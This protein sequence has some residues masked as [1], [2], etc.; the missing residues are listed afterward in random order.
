MGIE[1]ALITAAVGAGTS[2]YSANKQS[3]AAK[4]AGQVAQQ[5]AD[6]Q[7]ALNREIY[8]QQ[9][10]DYEPF[11]QF[12]IQRTNALGEMFGFDPVGGNGSQAGPSQGQYAGYGR[13]AAG[14][15][16]VAA[17]DDVQNAFNT[18]SPQNQRYLMAQGFDDNGDR[19]ISQG[20]YGNFHYN[21]HGSAEGRAMPAPQPGNALSGIVG[22]KAPVQSTAVEQP[23]PIDPANQ[24][25]GAGVAGAD[26]F[27]NSLFNAS[28]RNDFN[29]DRTAIDDNLA[30]SG[31]SYS[32]AR[33]EAVENARSQNFSNALGGYINTMMGAPS[34]GAATAGTVA[35]GGQFAAN[36]GNA[37]AGASSG[38][39]QSA[40]NRGNAAAAGAEGV[41]S[42][43][44]FG[45]GALPG[46]VFSLR[47]KK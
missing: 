17:N 16:Y 43:I 36:T 19:R 18:L 46:N 24:T 31:L 11:R 22:G 12:E 35:A 40:L 9:R 41:G 3:K 32:G 27:N 37:M 23:A 2:A 13:Q 14:S 15:G 42:A 45:L 6:Q 21:T 29:R 44:G 5:T 30:A 33:L 38:M 10:S 34:A 7:I 20:E 25:V 47:G 1:T 39:M 26:R 4:Q 28:F 8:N